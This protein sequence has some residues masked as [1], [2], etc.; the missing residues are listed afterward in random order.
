MD[1]L[2]GS[3]RISLSLDCLVKLEGDFI[4]RGIDFKLFRLFVPSGR[5]LSSWLE[6]PLSK[7]FRRLFLSITD[8]I[9]FIASVSNRREGIV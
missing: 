3:L 6:A 2:A 7:G 4:L 9:F 8:E 5:T 1:L